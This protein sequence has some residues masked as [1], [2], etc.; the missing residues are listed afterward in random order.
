MITVAGA[1][2]RALVRQPKGEEL[3]E[4]APDALKGVIRVGV[5]GE[6]DD[7]EGG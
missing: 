3:Q 1:G 5:E 2:S 4:L 7:G 6:Q